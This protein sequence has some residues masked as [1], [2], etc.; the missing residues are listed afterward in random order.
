MDTYEKKYKD[1]LER[2]KEWYNDPHITIGLK[3]NLKDIFPELKESEDKQAKEW[4]LEYLYDGLRKSDEQFKEQFKAAIN[5]LKKHWLESKDAIE[6]EKQDKSNPYS[7][8]SFEYNGHTWGMCARDNGV[9]ILLDKQIFKHLEKQGEQKPIISN[10]SLREGII[11][12]GITQYQI[13]NW[14]KKYVDVEK[15]GE[16]KPTDKVEPKFKVGDWIVYND[17]NVYQVKEIDY[18]NIIPHYELENIDGDKLS[19]P[20]TSDYNLRNWTI[21]DAKDGDVLVADDDKPF[22]FKGLLD[23]NHP[24]Y[25]VAH[26]G[27]D[28]EDYL[29]V[30]HSNVWW[31]DECV[32]PATIEQRNLLF[33]KMKEKGYEWDSEK[34]ELKKIKQKP[35]WSKEDEERIKQICEDLKCG[36]ENFRSGKN[37]KGLHFEEIINSNINWLKSLNPQPQWKPTEEQMEALNV[38]CKCYYIVHILSNNDYEKIKSLYSDLKKL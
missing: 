29:I 10:E 3:G 5:S 28:S 9:D 37:V 33:S 19:I 34:K 16:R 38:V 26:C 30:S 4:I 1:A 17:A 11:K 25:P 24:N 31:T 6:L 14:L 32:K 35:D 20:F 13:D 15:Q 21:G 27:L 12:F 22:I 2:A 23:P 8:V 7:G 36:L 18:T